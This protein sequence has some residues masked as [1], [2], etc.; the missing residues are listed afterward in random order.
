[1]VLKFVRDRF[2]QAIFLKI[3][4]AATDGWGAKDFHRYC[5]KRG[6]TLT[7]VETTKDFI[8]GG[9]TTEQ[10]ESPWLVL[11]SKRDPYSFLFS[12]NEG[13]KY[14]IMS[15][16]TKAIICHSDWSACFGWSELGIF[17]ASNK[18]THSYCYANYASFKLPA[19]KGSE[20]PSITGGEF[21]F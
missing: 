19:A 20:Y 1:M 8:F 12:V 14:P 16:D 18:N 2:P 3:Y 17:S 13:S 5:D 11:K 4:D 15:V 10:W 7:I 21:H 9:F 6:W